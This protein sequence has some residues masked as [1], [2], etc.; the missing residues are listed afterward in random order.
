MNLRVIGPLL[1]S[2]MLLAISISVKTLAF[3]KSSFP[4]EISPEIALWATGIFFSLAISEQTLLGGKAGYDLKRSSDNAIEI[5][6]R[7]ILPEKIEF[8]PK[9]TYLFLYGLMTWIISL[10]LSEKGALLLEQTKGWNTHTYLM[11]IAN[12]FVSGLAVGIA[13][14]SLKEVS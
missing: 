9:Y 10:L 11:C 6:Y 5:S 4:L 7:V 3:E 8:S 12:I 13:L 14:R 1:F 2:A